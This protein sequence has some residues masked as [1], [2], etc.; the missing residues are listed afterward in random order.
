MNGT[1]FDGSVQTLASIAGRR[2]ALRSISAGGMALLATLGLANGGEAT[3]K[4]HHHGGSKKHKPGGA[5]AE[6]KKG[7]GKPG[8][9]GPTGPTGPAGGGSGA[10]STGPTGAKGNIGSAGA[11]GPTGPKGNT[12]NTGNTGATGPAAPTPTITTV[13]GNT[14]GV[15]PG[16][17]NGGIG[18]CPSGT[19]AIDGSLSSNNNQCF[20]AYIDRFDSQ[21]FQFGVRCPAGQSASVTTNVTCIAFS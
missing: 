4:R 6:G 16:S 19:I 14:F 3:K 2:D 21:T 10:G 20:V 7:K 18:T 1:R 8:P 17:F 13:N 15:N 12:G 9:T 11:T 5:H